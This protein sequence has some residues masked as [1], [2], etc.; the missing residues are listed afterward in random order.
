MNAPL[1]I[2]R[3]APLPSPPREVLEPW[4]LAH[5][6]RDPTARGRLVLALRTVARRAGRTEL[7]EA[8]V[9]WAFARAATEGMQGAEDAAERAAALLGVTVYTVQMWR[10]EHPAVMVEDGRARNAARMRKARR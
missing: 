3:E 10:R 8:L 1:R 2:R 6:P 7:W 4:H 5:L 9:Q